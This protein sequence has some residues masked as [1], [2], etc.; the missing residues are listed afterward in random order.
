MVKR[1]VLLHGTNGDPSHGWQPWLKREL[2][3]HGYDVFSPQLPDSHHPDRQK[4]EAF[5]RESG[6]DFADNIIVG[7]SSG[8]TT[9]LNLLQGEWFPRV[10]AAVLVGTFLN[11]KLTKP[12]GEFPEGLFDGLF[13][14]RYEPARLAA[15]AEVFYFVHGSDDPYCDIADAKS[16][17]QQLDGEFIEIPQG[18]HLGSASGITELPQLLTALQADNLGL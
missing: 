6:W 2:E 11:E 5:L 9:V 16:L 18:H 17:C 4:Y 7:H 1:A 8:A 15:K 12:L 3:A 14:E 10:K 13:M